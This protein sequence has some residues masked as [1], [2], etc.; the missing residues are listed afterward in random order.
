M[1]GLPVDIKKLLLEAVVVSQDGGGIA[2]DIDKTVTVI[3][4]SPFVDYTTRE[5][6]V[7]VRAIDGVSLVPVAGGRLNAAVLAEE[8][9]N[10]RLAELL[11]QRD[12]G[13]CLE[14]GGRTTPRVR[15]EGE[16]ISSAH[17]TFVAFLGALHVVPGIKQDIA[18]IGGRVANRDLTI[19]VVLDVVLEVA[20]DG[21]KIRRNVL[22]GRDIVDDF[23]A[24]EEGEG[25]GVL[26]ES[27]DNTESVLKVLGVV[28][29]PRLE[30]GERLANKGRVDVKDH[31]HAGSIEDAGTLVV[32]GVRVEVVNT[33]SVHTKNLH[34]RSITQASIGVGKRIFPSL[35][36]ISCATTRL[37]GHANDL[38]L[39]AIGIDKVVA[40]DGERLNR[41][42]GGGAEGHKS[43]LKLERRDQQH[44]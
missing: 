36:V 12:V 24:G 4:L 44:V 41:R 6:L 38:E 18:D 26:A 1:E 5:V 42:D 13:G 25:V 17:V 31:V 10:G 14:G 21:T 40:R 16:E 34:E 23:V 28:A 32:V 27:L 30:G 33:D 22:S 43:R 20:G 15:V 11:D 9:R 35:G 7:H 19:N 3:L 2:A 37:V 39:V 8:D 29:G